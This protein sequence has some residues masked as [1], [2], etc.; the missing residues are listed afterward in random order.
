MKKIIVASNNK[1]KIQEIEAILK[2]I[3]IEVVSLK[4]EGIFIEV[5]ED[6]TTFK[7]NSYKKAKEIYDYLISKKYDNFIVMADDS[8]I[9]VDALNGEPGVYSARYAGEPSDSDKNN[10]KLL[11]NLKDIPWE[12]RGGSFICHITLIDDNG[13]SYDAEGVVRGIVTTELRGRDGFG[14]DPLF[15]IEKYKKTFGEIDSYEKNKISHR[16]LALGKVREIV[17]SIK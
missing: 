1:H 11:E 5:E 17:Q 14:Y 4:D 6:G 10:E 15:Y 9:S 8:G 3:D 2:D 7:E 13:I 16:S 12:N